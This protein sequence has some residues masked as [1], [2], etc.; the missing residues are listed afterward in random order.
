MKAVCLVLAIL[1]A[2]VL[3]A[4]TAPC[5]SDDVLR[6]CLPDHCLEEKY[7]PARGCAQSSTPEAEA[8]QVRKIRPP[9]SPLTDLELEDFESLQI[10][11]NK[12]GIQG[13]AIAVGKRGRYR[14]FD[15]PP[16]KT[17][18]ARGSVGE[19]NRVRLKG[20]IV[21]IPH[22][23]RTD[24]ANCRLVG[25]ANNNYVIH[26]AFL[27]DDTEFDSVVA[28]M[29][30]QRRDLNWNL[31]KLRKIAT[32]KRPIKITGQLFYDNKHLVN[33]DPDEELPG[34]PKRLSLWEIHPVTEMEVCNEYPE[35]LDQC[36]E[37]GAIWTPL[38]KWLSKQ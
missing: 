29:I 15:L 27:A 23:R 26:I 9:A 7:C 17:G 38:A 10:Q 5:I 11:A 21:G 8:N 32:D 12:Q 24:S 33:S 4:Q 3:T 16:A 20:Y 6:Q 34:H 14:R 18:K 30:A 36:F 37:K 25:R 22:A 28:E 19:G 35:K 1:V 31:E 2:S 13:F